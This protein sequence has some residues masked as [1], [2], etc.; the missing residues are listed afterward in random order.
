M[1][2]DD[3]ARRRFRQEALTLSKLNHPNIATV[4]DFDTQGGTDFLVTEYIPGTTLDA[5]LTAGPLAEKE[6][7]RLGTQLA[8]GLDAAHRQGVVHRD[9]KPGNL[10]LTADG[11]LKILD[12]GLAKGTLP[13]SASAVTTSPTQSP[14][15]TGTIPYMAPEQ[16]R[17][18]RPD[19]RSD[20]YSAGVVL[21]EMVTGRRPF[22]ET[23]LSRLVEA[24]LHQP[25]VPPSKINAA[26]SPE[27]ERIILKCLQK[28]PNNRYQSA[29]ELEEDL[30]CV[31]TG[32]TVA[33]ANFAST[34][35]SR[36]LLVFVMAIIA[37]SALLSAFAIGRWRGRIWGGTGSTHITSLAVLPLENI[38]GDPSQEYFVDGMTEE[39]TTKLAQISGLRIISRTSAMQYKHTHKALPEIA[40]ELHVDAVVEGSVMRSDD[41]VRITAQLIEAAADRHLWAKDYQHPLR[42]VLRLQ[43]Q[44]AQSIVNEVK[45]KLT[46]QE[47]ARLAGS[48]LVNSKAYE[49]YLK[50]RYHFHQGTEDQFREAK[51]YFEQATKIDLNYAPAYVGLADYYWVTND[52]SP[53]LAIPRAKDL[54]VKAL[55]IDDALAD[56]H[57]T[58][59]AIRLYGD[60]DWSGADKEFKRAI[61]LNPSYAEAHR[62]YSDFLSEMGRHDQALVEIRKAQ[63][64]D[65]LSIITSV[66]AAWTF[67][68]ARQ[69]DRAIEQCR[70]VLNW[71][72]HSVSA[73]DCL[74][75]SYTEKGAYE[76]AITEYRAVVSASGSD[77][78][79]LAGLGRAVA[80]AGKRADA[81]KVVEQLKEESK[82]HYV[83][84]Y[85]LAVIYAALSD[86]DQAF[87]WL[88][89]ACLERDSYLVR[90]KV[91][92]ALDSLRSDSRFEYLLRRVG[93]PR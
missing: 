82:T 76:E 23:F 88:D 66:T 39:L 25:S 56:A 17:G 61:E 2:A 65:P 40:R 45:I 4:F 33:V 43:D 77:S 83:A 55:A 15:I 10:R 16:L 51:A 67:Y 52:L 41:S 30:C 85:F 9:I 75:S 63:E 73:H 46:P 93:L 59:A 81:Q 90:L 29:A 31:V 78:L 13:V 62:M 5:K 89:R 68:Y 72:P 1:L 54:V 71:Y 20:V 37:V 21:Y 58:L 19:T 24:I 48:H 38:S 28:E 18:G 22:R 26:V 53:R 6:V 49:A 14:E 12:F 35:R 8:D 3:E 7:L 79:R 87:S 11:V 32:S 70:K 36:R 50:G 64:L 44:V 84:P 60:W 57:S 69:Y 47:Q 92:P 42:D 91:D 74:G 34:T 80:A 27:L 86:K